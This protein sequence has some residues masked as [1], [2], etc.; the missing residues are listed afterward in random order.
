VEHY[1]TGPAGGYE[2]PRYEEWR[3]NLREHFAISLVF[4]NRLKSNDWRVLANFT[5]HAPVL[6]LML[7][8]VLKLNDWHDGCIP[9]TSWISRISSG[10]PL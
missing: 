1:A 4:P 8:N 5:F 6:L 10:D 9:L 2:L 7:H 3:K